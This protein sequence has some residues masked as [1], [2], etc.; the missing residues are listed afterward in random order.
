MTCAPCGRIFTQNRLSFFPEPALPALKSR[1]PT[2]CQIAATSARKRAKREGLPPAGA[3]DRGVRFS[4]DREPVADAMGLG[5]ANIRLR[6]FVSR[7]SSI[8]RTGAADIP[9]LNPDG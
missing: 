8:P 6:S 7:K 9:G 3:G 5:R 4:G 1:F 2:G